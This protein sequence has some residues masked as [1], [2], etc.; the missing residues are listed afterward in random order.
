MLVEA[1]LVV[2]ALDVMKA[3]RVAAVVPRKDASLG[4]DLDAK[5]VAAPFGEDLISAGLGVIPP[6]QLPHRVHG[7]FASVKPGRVTWPV[8][9]IPGRHRASHQVP[10]AGC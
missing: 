3:T 5:G 9:V 4:V 7:L 6:D 1:L 10:I 8:T 2:A